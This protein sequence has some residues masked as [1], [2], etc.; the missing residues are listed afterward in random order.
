MKERSSSYINT[1]CSLKA[2]ETV[3]HIFLLASEQETD[4]AI[5]IIL[6]MYFY[7]TGSSIT[8]LEM[9]GHEIQK[10]ESVH[11]EKFYVHKRQSAASAIIMKK[12]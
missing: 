7:S 5:N 12:K 3:N 4:T 10:S 1:L 11:K 2:G 9:N 8:D 6:T